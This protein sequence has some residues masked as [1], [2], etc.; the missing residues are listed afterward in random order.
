MQPDEHND[1]DDHDD[2]DTTAIPT[3]SINPHGK[4]VDSQ[5]AKGCLVA[6]EPEVRA[7]LKNSY[8]TLRIHTLE[9]KSREKDH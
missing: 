5:V 9:R 8:H 6:A 2:H 3:G 4:Y 7:L 1:H